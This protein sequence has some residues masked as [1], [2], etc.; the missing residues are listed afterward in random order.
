MPRRQRAYDRPLLDTQRVAVLG[1]TLAATNA[2][3]PRGT[4][5]VSL[6]GH[7]EEPLAASA[8]RPRAPRQLSAGG[9]DAGR[10]GA[11]SASSGASAGPVSIVEDSPELAPQRGHACPRPCRLSL[12]QLSAAVLGE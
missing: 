4:H 5:V 3:I 12:G 11:S 1:D 2:A 8:K 9:Y 6:K 7:G 10:G